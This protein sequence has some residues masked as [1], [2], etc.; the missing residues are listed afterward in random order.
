MNLNNIKK[1]R[2]TKSILRRYKKNM[3]KGNTKVSLSA[4]EANRRAKQSGIFNNRYN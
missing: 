1:L 4:D 2:S 3:H